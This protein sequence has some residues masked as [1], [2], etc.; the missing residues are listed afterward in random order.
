M[1]YHGFWSNYWWHQAITWT[2]VDWLISN[3]IDKDQVLY[4]HR[5]STLKAIENDDI[6]LKSPFR[7]SMIMREK[8]MHKM[9][10]KHLKIN[11]ASCCRT[12]SVSL[13]E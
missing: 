1:F 8:E 9:K 7:T 13:T 4:M 10:I 11:E 12:V 5:I 2:D 6:G 3:H